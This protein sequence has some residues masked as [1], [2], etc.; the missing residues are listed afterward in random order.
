MCLQK[1]KLLLVAAAA[2]TIWAFIQSAS[3][4]NSGIGGDSFTRLLWRGTDGS[5][6]L[7]KLDPN[8][9][10]VINRNYPQLTN[11]SQ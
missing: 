11:G 6:A 3:A 8:L 9:N 1:K 5:V 2:I 4:Q 10:L 7:Y